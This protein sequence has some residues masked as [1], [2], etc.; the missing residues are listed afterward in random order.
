MLVGERV[1][2]DVPDFL[3]LALTRGDLQGLDATKLLP[4]AAKVDDLVHPEVS[5]NPFAIESRTVRILVN[6]ISHRLLPLPP[7]LPAVL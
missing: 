1:C 3:N 5:G 7:M 2:V 6:V 4:A